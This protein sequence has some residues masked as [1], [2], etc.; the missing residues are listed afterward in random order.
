M[1]HHEAATACEEDGESQIA[2]I[3]TLQESQYL[4]NIIISDIKENLIYFNNDC[5]KL[6]QTDNNQ[7]QY[8][9]PGNV[10]PELTSVWSPNFLNERDKSFLLD[11]DIPFVLK[12]DDCYK[13]LFSNYVCEKKMKNSTN[14]RQIGNYSLKL[15]C[16]DGESILLVQFCDGKSDCQDK[17]DEEDCLKKCNLTTQRQCS[18]G[19]CIELEKWCDGSPNCLDISDEKSCYNIC[20]GVV[21]CPNEDDEENCEMI[22]CEEK[23]QFACLKEP[24]CIM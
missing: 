2:Y 16:K 18:S 8:Y 23:G 22:N 5:I 7:V 4:L 20:D 19:E 17:S 21:H 12:E 15:Q 14:Y 3:N 13:E 6:R 10:N 11:I 1:S 9:S 24:R